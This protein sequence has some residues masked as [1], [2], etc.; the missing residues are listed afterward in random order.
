MYFHIEEKL[1]KMIVRNVFANNFEFF[2]S[3][4]GTGEISGK[5]AS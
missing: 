5:K 3:L 4:K 2:T 1:S